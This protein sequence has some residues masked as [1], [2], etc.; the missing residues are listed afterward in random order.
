MVKRQLSDSL[1]SVGTWPK[2][3]HR[4]NGR[5]ITQAD[6]LP[7]WVGSEAGAAVDRAVNAS[8]PG[9]RTQDNLDARTDC[10][11]VGFA[12]HQLELHPMI[13]VGRIE[14]Q[15][16]PSAIACISAAQGDVNILSPIVIQIGE[17]N[18]VT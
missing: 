3:L 16:V 17:S 4:G 12:S 18:P 11:P 9:R 1:V 5:R 6:F 2:D 10:R 8:R 15:S 13:R 14:E 7:Q